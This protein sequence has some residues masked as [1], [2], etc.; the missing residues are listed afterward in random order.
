M[1]NI[2]YTMGGCPPRSVLE[3]LV[4]DNS[5]GALPEV[6]AAH[7]HRCEQ[8]HAILDGMTSDAGLA[9]ALS[10]S[11]ADECLSSHFLPP[12]PPAAIP[13]YLLCER[14]SEG[15]QG[16]V[17][18]AVSV[19]DTLAGF[20]VKVCRP[21]DKKARY[22]FEREAA[23][24]QQIRHGSV[25]KVHRFGVIE[26]FGQ[27]M[28]YIVLDYISGDLITEYVK[29]HRLDLAAVVE[30]V[31]KCCEPLQSAHARGIVHRDI[32]PRNV[33]VGANARP[34]LIDFGIAHCE[35]GG[36]RTGYIT[37]AKQVLGTLAYMSPE[38]L[39]GDHEQ[40]GPW[41]D[42]FG[43]AVVLYELLAGQHPYEP[44][45]RKPLALLRAMEEHS[46]PLLG[47]AAPWRIFPPPLERAVMKSLHPDPEGRY[48]T[49]NQFREA[50]R[51]AMQDQTGDRRA[52][53]P[54]RL[55]AA[56]RRR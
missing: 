32:K 55:F 18:R 27:E 35:L 22:R 5:H 49:A 2:G 14:I 19:K 54:R 21:C 20:A 17:Y 23:I 45:R 44:L 13:G 9:T 26:H 4:A 1:T 24:L 52:R 34:V 8:C 30:L 31:T 40:V 38:Q 56:A 11:W 50:L 36:E 51:L 25:P 39:R 10:Q 46:A 7:V 28:P 42:V 47:E 43:L 33:L 16:V 29:K 3:R 12:L 41:S 15:A 48:A 6:I 53:W 37:S